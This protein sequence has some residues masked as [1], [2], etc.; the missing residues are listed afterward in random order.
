MSYHGQIGLSTAPGGTIQSGSSTTTS[1][2]TEEDEET[3]S[4]STAFL[5]TSFPELPSFDTILAS[6]DRVLFYVHSNTILATC[7]LAFREFLGGSLD[8]PNFR[9]ILI[10]IPSTSAE[11]NV[12]LHMFYGLSPAPYSPTFEILSNAVDSMPTYSITPSTHIYPETP[13]YTLLLSY[14]PLCPLDVYALAAHHEVHSLAVLTSSHLL[15]YPLHTI[16]D[17]QADRMGAVYLKRLMA[18]HIDRLNALKD[19]LLKPPYPHPPTRV[20]GF[21][22]QRKLTREWSLVSANLAWEASPGEFLFQMFFSSYSKLT[23]AI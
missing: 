17:G 16:T 2:L 4:V 7:E 1:G 6:S 11:L 21:L 12:I 3:A 5:P 14:A 13:L 20:C 18:L 9:D 23:D 10:P 22:S 15:S 19:V 8:N